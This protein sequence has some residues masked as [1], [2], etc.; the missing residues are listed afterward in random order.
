[1]YRSCMSIEESKT[2]LMP[3]N[4]DT[5]HHVTPISWVQ[6]NGLLFRSILPYKLPNAIHHS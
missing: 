5:N 4:L 6:T 1:M 3:K 2:Y